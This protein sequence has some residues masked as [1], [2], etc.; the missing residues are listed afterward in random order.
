M[1]GSNYYHIVMQCTH[2]V[3]HIDGVL[4]PPS[5]LLSLP[6][7]SFFHS[8]LPFPL[9]SPSSLLPFL[10][11]PSPS[12]LLPFLPSPL[13][14]LSFPSSP[15]PLLPLSF[16]SLPLPSP[17][18]SSPS[19]PSSPHQLPMKAVHWR[20]TLVLFSEPILK[21]KTS[22]KLNYTHAHTYLYTHSIH[23]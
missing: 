1:E 5:S 22:S 17:P 13:L 8:S 9:P 14:P 15:S 16:P 10:P 21:N 18:S 23:M 12:S 20:N 4:A 6:F 3:C 7:L 11:V 2:A 19:Y